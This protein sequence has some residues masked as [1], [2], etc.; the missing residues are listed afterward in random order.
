MFLPPQTVAPLDYNHQ[1][2][3]SFHDF[4]GNVA[5]GN[6]VPSIKPLPAPP[7]PPA[8]APLRA[9]SAYNFYFRYQRERILNGDDLNNEN[10]DSDTH[11]NK[12]HQEA[13][14]KE[15]WGRDRTVKRRHRK[16]HGKISFADLSKKISQSWKALP[17]PRKDFFREVAGKDWARYHRELTQHK[18]DLT[19]SAEQSVAATMHPLLGM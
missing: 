19:T 10:E 16:S 4:L 15:H 6:A 5:P 17:E 9:L 18:L 11:W 13:L 7:T 3:D 12:E 2:G 14:L 8:E 1:S